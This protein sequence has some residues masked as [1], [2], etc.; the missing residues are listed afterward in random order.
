MNDLQENA[1]KQPLI[2]KFTVS[3]YYS[4]KSNN[5]LEERTCYEF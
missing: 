2:T 5:Y 1:D 4:T 3:K